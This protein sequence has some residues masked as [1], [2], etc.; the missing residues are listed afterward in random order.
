MKSDSYTKN[1]AKINSVK[2]GTGNNGYSIYGIGDI[3][4]GF[5]SSN[6]DSRDNEGTKGYKKHK[7][8]RVM[9]TIEYIAGNWIQSY[10]GIYT[11]I[12]LNCIGWVTYIIRKN[13]LKNDDHLK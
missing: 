13:G 10:E 11:L 7:G 1:K 12:I 4:N 5:Y 2:N 3:H 8:Y 9:S 6:R